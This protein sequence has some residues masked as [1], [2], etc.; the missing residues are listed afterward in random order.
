MVKDQEN[1]PSDPFNNFEIISLK[2]VDS[3][4]HNFRSRKPLRLKDIHAHQYQL[5]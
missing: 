2:T 3:V 4:S 1:Q 5:Q